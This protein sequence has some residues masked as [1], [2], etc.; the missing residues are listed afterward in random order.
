MKL[1]SVFEQLDVSPHNDKKQSFLLSGIQSLFSI[2]YKGI[3]HL[4]N[5]AKMGNFMFYLKKKQ[6]Q[7]LQSKTFLIKSNK[8]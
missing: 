3:H 4:M 2:R 8:N 5:N 7:H 1:D 6:F